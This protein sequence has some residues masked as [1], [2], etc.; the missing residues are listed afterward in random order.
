MTNISGSVLSELNRQYNQELGAAHGYRALSLWCDAQNFKGFARF[1]AKQVA[2]EYVHAAKFSAYIIDRGEMPE[3]A[4]LPAPKTNYKSVLEAAQT[5]QGMEQH[6][7]KGIYA[8]YEA[9][10]TA[11]DYSTTVFLQWFINE[12]IEEEAWALEM[13][14]RVQAATCAGGFSDLDRHIERYLAEETT[15]EA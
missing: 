4:G 12:Q 2:E 7:S 5:A 1:F 15:A 3:T 9:A 10:M 6:N 11:K 13:V 14:E 8:A